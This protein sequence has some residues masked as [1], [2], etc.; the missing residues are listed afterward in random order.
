MLFKSFLP[1]PFEQQWWI[2]IDEKDKLP[3]QRIAMEQEVHVFETK[4]RDPK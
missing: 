3:D 1:P 4:E 2:G